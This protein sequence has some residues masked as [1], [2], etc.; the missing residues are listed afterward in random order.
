MSIKGFIA[1]LSVGSYEEKKQI[2]L[3]FQETHQKIWFGGSD[4]NLNFVKYKQKFHDD[5]IEN[6]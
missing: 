2:K 3:L 4:N 6:F 1:N 5:K